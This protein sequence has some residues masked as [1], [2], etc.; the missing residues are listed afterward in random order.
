V[1][2]GESSLRAELGLLPAIALVINATIGTGIFR[3]P[4]AVARHAGSLEWSLGVWALGALVALAGA[5][6]VAELSASLPRAGGIYEPLR[7]A[8]GPRVA[9]LYAFAKIVL[10]APSA[11]GS[12]AIL[13]AEAIE[14]FLGLAPDRA[15]EVVLALIVLGLALATNLL[16]VKAGG[17]IQSVVTALK[18]G[19]LALLAVAGL[20]LPFTPTIAPVADHAPSFAGVL[21]AMVSVMWAYDGWADLASVAGETKDPSRTLPRALVLGTVAVALAYVATNLGYARVLGFDG[22]AAAGAGSEMP[23]AA[24]ASATLGAIGGRA[25]AALVL[26]S[27]VGGCMASLLTNSRAFVPMATDVPRF[28]WLG[29]VHVTTGTPRT[30][31]MIT[32]ALGGLYVASR[33]FEELTDGFVV[34]YFPFYALAVIALFVLRR[35]EPSLARPFKTPLL[36]PIVF[37]LGAALVMGGAVID[38]GSRLLVPGIVLVVGALVA[39]R[40]V[41]GAA[42]SA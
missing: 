26:V 33:T 27:C 7:R 20:A 14:A 11:V 29:Q 37:L 25:L 38:G 34:G 31:V 15:R 2:S 9:F 16:R 36:A 8:F 19:G 17:A 12:F 40:F 22:L 4:A 28:A 21:A 1:R 10:L 35:R 23:G 13:A 24:L 18:Y 32:G 6:S 3:T 5:L 30:A 39:W 42:Q 41:D